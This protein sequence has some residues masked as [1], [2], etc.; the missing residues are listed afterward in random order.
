MSLPI[1][2]A[3]MPLPIPEITPPVTKMYFVFGFGLM[4]IKTPSQF[5]CL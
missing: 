3:V 4:I 5:K 1:E 2:A